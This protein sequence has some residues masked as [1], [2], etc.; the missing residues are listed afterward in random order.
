[1]KWFQK[2]PVPFYQ[3][4]HEIPAPER[5]KD[6]YVDATTQRHLRKAT[7]RIYVAVGAFLFCLCIILG[8]LF[9]LTVLSYKKTD[10][11]PWRVMLDEDLPRYNIVDRNGTV[12]ATTLTSWD[13]SVNPTKVKNP[14]EVAHQL[15]E[16]L[17]GV[18]EKDILEKLKSDSNFKYI[19][20][21]A[22]PKELEA[23]NWLGYH[24]LTYEVVDK[25]AYPQGSLFSHIL[26][27]V[28]IDNVGIAGI[29]KSFDNEL[30]EHEIQL[31]LDVSVQEMVRTNLQKGIQKY[32]AE[33]GL[34]IV[35]DINTG[36]I[37][38]SVSLPDY[39]PELPA[40]K[41]ATERFNMPTLGVYEFGSVFK[42]FNTAMVL[43][44]KVVKVTD[45]I[46]ATHPLKIGKKTME[47]FRGQKRPLTVAEILMHSSNIGSAKMALEAGYEK[48]R[49]FLQKFNL[50]DKLPIPLP[51]RGTPLYNTKDKWA[52][53]ETANVAF[54]Y[55]IAVT[56][57]HLVAGV[58]ALTNGGFYNVPTFIKDGNKDKATMQVL[59]SKISEQLRQMMW[60]V[61]NWDP[62][63]KNPAKHYAVGGKT[64]TANMKEGATYNTNK[65]R[66][67]FIGVFPVTDP[68]YIV[69][70]SLLNPKIIKEISNFNNAGWNAKPVGLAII[71]EIAPYLNVAPVMD[72][73]PPEFV[74]KSIDISLVKNGRNKK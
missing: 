50:F 17:E 11:H 32:K 63:S 60:A 48:Q 25:R 33:G 6:R 28:N 15:A 74:Q 49:A 67:S 68:K 73:K 26:G 1:M 16:K 4:C 37:L 69:Q 3:P 71:N 31:S 7:N 36:E 51:E 10:I 21:G 56:P 5:E 18:K 65:V 22:T 24:F 54:G 58:A 30:K 57:L 23:I 59:D 38:A 13:I 42:L 8:Q 47:D 27:G 64:G 45:V 2:P 12:L 34:G 14:E 43:E 53:I 52:D 35:M 66:T 46:D 39:D 40:G 55:G 44:N 9:Y 29:E 70:V 41:D 20:R 61:I 62:W 72:Y 19:K